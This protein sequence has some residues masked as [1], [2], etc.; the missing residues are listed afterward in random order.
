MKI[1]Y[2]ALL[3]FTVFFSSCSKDGLS[4]NETV[5]TI[6]SCKTFTI[7]SLPIICL[8]SITSDS[9]CPDGAVCIWEGNAEVNL[10][11]KTNTGNQH[12]KLSSLSKSFLPPNDTLIAGY[13]IKLID[14]KPY[15]SINALSTETPSIVL[16]INK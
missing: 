13:H 14:V 9:R 10:T 12:F 16:H 7:N 6:G 8:D 5:L 11:L 2:L 3:S 4:N 1:I 15:P